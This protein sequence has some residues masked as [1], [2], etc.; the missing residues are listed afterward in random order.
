MLSHSD[1]SDTQQYTMLAQKTLNYGELLDDLPTLQYGAI[2]MVGLV[3]YRNMICH[4][5]CF[6]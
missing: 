3:W 1:L 6:A 2:D 4:A 5:T